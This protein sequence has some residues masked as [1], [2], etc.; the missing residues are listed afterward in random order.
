M[1]EWLGVFAAAMWI[2]GLAWLLTV[3]GFARTFRDKTT[4]QVLGEP[5]YRLATTSGILLFTVGMAL[6]V[7]T[8]YERAGWIVVALLTIWDGITVWQ[9]MRKS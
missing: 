4:R 5:E 2:G 8:W 6:G 3:L 7:N 1:I 9:A